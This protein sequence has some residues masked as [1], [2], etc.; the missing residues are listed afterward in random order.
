MAKKIQIMRATEEADY[1]QSAVI[2]T[3][4]DPWAKLGRTYEYSY[5]KVHEMD[6]ELIVA[7]TEEKVIGC[8]LLEMHSTLKAFV[9]ALC[10]TAEYR[11]LGVGADLLAFAEHRAFKETANVFLFVSNERA[12]EFYKNNGYIQVG[13]LKDLNVTGTNEY[14]MRKTIGPND[15]V[16]YNKLE[17][18][19][20]D[21]DGETLEDAIRN[22]GFE[23]CRKGLV[24]ENYA[25]KC[26][27][28]EMV[29]S[30]GLPTNIPVAI[31][32]TDEKYV[33]RDCLCFQRMKRP[34]KAIEIGG[35]TELACSL[36]I[37][38]GMTGSGTQVTML[39][40]MM[41]VLQDDEFMD[42]C[43]NSSTDEVKKKV[44]EVLGNLT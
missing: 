26:I 7:K 2:L 18:V 17:V 10:V 14:I 3:V 44:Q 15:E 12:R 30:T 34:V 9:R 8:L 33:N 6:A 5:A 40:K 16:E 22:A 38:M 21:G 36:V 25:Q 32:H 28:R 1:E 35:T 20:L 41:E 31:P 42:V 27:E 19:V 37:N 13:E 23:M 11:S 29:F 39:S 4:N 24:R 43:L